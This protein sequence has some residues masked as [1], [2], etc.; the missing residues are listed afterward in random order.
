MSLEGRKD[1]GLGGTG[2]SKARWDLLPFD[3]VDEVV[4]V[5]THGAGKYGDRNWEKGMKWS[6]ILAAT[7]RHLVAFARGQR[8]DPET[9]LHPLAH[10][11]CDILF[12]LAY[13]LRGLGENDLPREVTFRALHGV[14]ERAT[15]DVPDH[16]RT[17][18]Y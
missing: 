18:G 15:V 8:R 6:R 5:L 9:G 14:R 4:K 17:S 11:A 3:A 12:L 2:A 10:A 1:D 13:E 7:F 16:L